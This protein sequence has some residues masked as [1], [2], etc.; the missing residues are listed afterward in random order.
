MDTTNNAGMSDAEMAAG[1][2]GLP[3]PP[4]VETPAPPAGVR[5]LTDVKRV[6]H[7]DLV[8]PFAI[9]DVEYRRLTVK[10]LTA[11]EV[12]AYIAKLRGIPDEVPNPRFPMFFHGDAEISDEVWDA[13]DDDDRVALVELSDGFLSARFRR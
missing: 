3:A 9:G 10:R 1:L 8:F 5:W 12:A 7:Y 2:A 6:E 13:M 4:L 11:G